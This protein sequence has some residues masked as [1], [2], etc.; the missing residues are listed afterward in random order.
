MK[1]RAKSNTWF[2]EGTEVKLIDDYRPQWNAGLFEGI[3]TCENPLSE[4]RK[5]GEKYFDGEV[6]N[7]DEFD[8]VEEDVINAS[9]FYIVEKFTR[10]QWENKKNEN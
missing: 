2:D 8:E 5:L 3:R 10:G 7:F 1:Y 4:N 6:C 9:D